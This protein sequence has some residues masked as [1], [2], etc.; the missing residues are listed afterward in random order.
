MEEP[1]A[2]RT[3]LIVSVVEGKRGYIKDVRFS[4]N[5]GLSEK[6][7]RRQ[8]TTKGRG[9]FHW[10]TNSGH[11][12]D[13]DWNDDMNAVVGL[14]QKS[15]YAR[16]KVLGVDNTWDDRG[17]IV[18]TIRVEEGPRYRAREIILQGND[19]FL[20]SEFLALIRNKVGEYLD[21]AGAEADQEA[22]AAHY[23]DAGYLDVRVDSEVLFERTLLR[24]AL[25]DR[26]GTSLPPRE[27][28]GPGDAPH[29]GRGDPAR[30][31]DRAGRDGR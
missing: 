14:Y 17:G 23:R 26:R 27:H 13:E 25:R 12:R 1:S 28:R 5:R 21:Y 30:E 22:V 31:P 11:Y 4:G 3:P 24:A 9:V 16:M 6:V 20:R 2:G 18:K 10:I 8:M 15:G 7:L 19:H 29:P